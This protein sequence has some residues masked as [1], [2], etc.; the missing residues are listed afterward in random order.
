MLAHWNHASLYDELLET[1]PVVAVLECAVLGVEAPAADVRSLGNDHSVGTF[2]GNYDL[3]GDGVRLD[4]EVE[5]AVLRQTAHAAE[6]KLGLS[7]D[8]HWPTGS[9]W[10]HFLDHPVVQW[11]H[12]V[13]RGFDQP[14]A[15]QFMELF[16]HL[17]GQIVRLAP[18]FGGVIKLPEVVIEGRLLDVQGGPGSTVMGYGGPTLM[19]N[20]AVT[21]HLEILR[22]M[23]FCGSGV[24]KG[25]EHADALDGT[26]LNAVDKGRL[27]KPG[28][29]KNGWRNVDDVMELRTEFA[30]PLNS[31]WP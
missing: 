31:L 28:R 11:Q 21:E 17:L 10:V 14:Q 8:K 18:I 25:V 20:A 23:L 3:G 1:T 12:L 27:R 4:L 24:I 22:L 15:L 6:K 30:R 29:F 16:R 9:V 19:E 13:T 26:L 7:F 2:F 5:N